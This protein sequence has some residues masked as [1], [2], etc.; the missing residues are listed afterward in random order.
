MKSGMIVGDNRSALT[1]NAFQR[2]RA[3]HRI[4]RAL[5]RARRADADRVHRKFS[6]PD[7]R[8]VAQQD[9]FRNRARTRA[10]IARPGLPAPTPSA[11]T[12]QWIMDWHDLHPLRKDP[13]GAIVAN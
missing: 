8:R 1:S 7:S 2:R 11:R 6:R 5:H 12:R 9:M 4:V 3:T 10:V 13:L